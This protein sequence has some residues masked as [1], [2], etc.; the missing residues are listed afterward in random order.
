MGLEVAGFARHVADERGDGAAVCG[1][2]AVL[3]GQVSV[4]QR[5]LGGVESS[6]V[7]FERGRMALGE[8]VE[9]MGGGLID[10]RLLGGELL[11]EASVGQADRLPARIG[12]TAR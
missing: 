8:F 9:G 4:D 10:E 7:L 2:V 6:G 3:D 5:L 12:P 1:I 11:V